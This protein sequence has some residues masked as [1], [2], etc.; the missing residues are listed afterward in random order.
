MELTRMEKTSLITNIVCIIILVN[1]IIF[2]DF[3]INLFSR[4]HS[5]FSPSDPFQDGFGIFFIYMMTFLII[6]NIITIALIIRPRK[7]SPDLVEMT[8]DE[9][10]EMEQV[11]NKSQLHAEGTIQSVLN[12]VGYSDPIYARKPI[13]K[14]PWREKGILILT[15]KELIF[16]GKEI[17]FSI[18]ISEI[19]TIRPFITKGGIRTFKVCEVNH[20]LQ[21]E[22]AIFMGVIGYFAFDPP[23]ELELKSMKLME[24]LKK[25]HD[26]WS[27]NH[28]SPRTLNDAI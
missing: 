13:R 7:L 5:Y 12:D 20:G 25:W 22:G 15:D 26:T 28:F 10:K 11:L 19:N 23:S 17:Q 16:L 9:M 18:S 1:L 2:Y 24:Y 4:S 21:E 14:Y 3:F 8:E 6:W 27:Q